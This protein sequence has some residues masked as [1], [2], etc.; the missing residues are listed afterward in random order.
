MY[1]AIAE[2]TPASTGKPYHVLKFSTMRDMKYCPLIT[3]TTLVYSNVAELEQFCSQGELKAIW[4]TMNLSA[5]MPNK[6]AAKTL[7]DFVL[8][9]ATTWKEEDEPMVESVVNKVEVVTE[10]PVAKSNEIRSSIDKS[11]KIV[12]IGEFKGRKGTLR[13]NALEIALQSKTVA[14]ALKSMGEKGFTASVAN[15]TL[16]FAIAE[17]LIT[18]KA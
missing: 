8:T 3:K 6:M 4:R 13:S 16:R 1:Y 2:G 15:S 11:S 17:K 12:V 18:L 7:H 14:E 5:E 9:K 10:T